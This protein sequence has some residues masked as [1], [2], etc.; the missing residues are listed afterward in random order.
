VTD[1]LL[2]F[3]SLLYAMQTDQHY[4]YCNADNPDEDHST[5][6]TFG[7]LF[8]VSGFPYDN[9]TY[10]CFGEFARALGM[11]KC[12]ND[13]LAPMTPWDFSRNPISRKSARELDNEYLQTG[14]WQS[15]RKQALERAGYRC[16]VCNSGGVQ[17]DVHHRTDETRG[18]EILEDLI[19]LCHERHKLFETNRRILT[20]R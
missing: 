15:T 3:E 8:V 6:E 17:L 20:V 13:K 18:R 7:E 5:V 19:V 2:G 1:L 4:Q 11:E 12:L 16:L 9:G 10:K 14:H